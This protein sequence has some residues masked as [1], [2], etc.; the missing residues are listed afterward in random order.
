MSHAFQVDALLILRL[1]S[2]R[3]LRLLS[4]LLLVLPRL[5]P[6]LTLLVLFPTLSTDELLLF[7]D[8]EAL[9]IL[10]LLS[11]RLVWS[12]RLLLVDRSL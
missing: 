8:C 3:L 10:R 12:V 9:L 4:Q 11:L 6:L 7:V 5:L 1:L 2:L